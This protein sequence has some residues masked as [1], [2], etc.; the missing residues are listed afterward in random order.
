MKTR[1]RKR[2]ELLEK[3]SKRLVESN[4]KLEETFE[5]FIENLETFVEV[6]KADRTAANAA[7]PDPESANADIK[8]F[9]RPAVP[10]I[11][12][13]RRWHDDL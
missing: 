3:A 1:A 11:D 12:S 5:V 6:M 10:S 2:R 7:A 13:A 9:L 8:P 4:T